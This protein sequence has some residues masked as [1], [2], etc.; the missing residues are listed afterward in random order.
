[1]EWG[2]AKWESCKGGVLRWRG[3]AKWYLSGRGLSGGEPGAGPTRQ[4]G[5]RSRRGRAAEVAV[6]RSELRLLGSSPRWRPKPQM[7][8]RAEWRRRSAA[9]L[10][11]KTARK[12][13]RQPPGQGSGGQNVATKGCCPVT[14]LVAS[15]GLRA[16]GTSAGQPV[17]RRC[18]AV[19]V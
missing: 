5:P 8:L 1:M 17:S 4:A 12:P 6:P 10:S 9:S 13:R 16:D 11:T 2:G 19:G 14:Q 15:R 18:S 3:G 7:P